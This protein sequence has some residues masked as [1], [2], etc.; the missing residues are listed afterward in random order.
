MSAC[1]A[2]TYLQSKS[3]APRN[4]G[5]A[6]PR[7]PIAP[8]RLFW[9]LV[10][11]SK[12]PDD[13]PEEGASSWLLAAAQ[14]VFSM[15]GGVG[16]S[17]GSGGG[18]GA[19]GGADGGSGG[20][21]LQ[22]IFQRYS[23]AIH[24][25][26]PRLK[27]ALCRHLAS[28]AMAAG[29]FT[30]PLDADEVLAGLL[31]ASV[32]GVGRAAGGGVAAPPPS[33]PQQRAA[34]A[35]GGTAP[36]QPPA[37]SS[38]A[39]FHRVLPEVT[40]LANL[41]LSARGVALT[42]LKR[43]VDHPEELV[44][45]GEGGEGGEYGEGGGGEGGSGGGVGSGGSSGGGGGGGSGG[46]SGGGGGGGG[47][48]TAGGG[49]GS[50]GGYVDMVAVLSLLPP[51]LRAHL[52][53]HMRV[54]AAAAI[55]EG[56]G[57]P[58]GGVEGLGEWRWPVKVYSDVDDT[59]Q[60]RLYDHSFPRHTTYPGYV[61][62]IR[63]L[64]GQPPLLFSPPPP[65]RGAAAAPPPQPP[66]PA[67]PPPAPPPAPP[68]PT[69]PPP[70]APSP[71]PPS[72]PPPPPAP[73]PPGSALFRL[74]LGSAGQGA[75][76]RRL[77]PPKAP[78]AAPP[79]AAVRPPLPQRRAARGGG[80]SGGGEGGEGDAPA[81]SSLPPGDLIFLSARPAF[82]RASTLALAA[83]VGLGGGAVLCGTLAAALT[84]SRMAGRK[85]ANHLIHASCF[86]E[87]RFVF[88]GD[89]GQADVAFALKMLAAHASVKAAVT[90]GFSGAAPGT[91]EF[92]RRRALCAPPPLVLIHDICGADG[93]P[94][95]PSL[96]RARL[97]ARGVH[98]VDSYIDAAVE[99]Y[100]CDLLTDEQLRGV[101]DGATEDL[102]C[103]AWGESGSGG[104]SGSGVGGGLGL[105]PGGDVT[106]R[107]RRHA[108]YRTALM[109]AH[110]ALGSAE[111]KRKPGAALGAAVPVGPAA[112]QHAAQPSPPPAPAAPAAAPQPPAAAEP[113]P[114]PLPPLPLPPASP[115][116]DA[117]AAAQPATPSAAS[118]DAL[119]DEDVLEA[120]LLQEDV[121]EAA[122]LQE[123]VE[124]AVY[125]DD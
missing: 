118:A 39:N 57:G 114:P 60:V 81:S 77:V 55:L 62:L 49:A 92:D 113:A 11:A 102:A 119:F 13:K 30:H 12:M 73:P 115:P 98:V 61:H 45:P 46:G 9:M 19:S 120:A 76:F 32:G 33:P 25:L 74:G 99:A 50:D 78:S 2:F 84:H 8:D 48:P 104:G 106:M 26:P 71:P 121:E 28:R 96:Q 88:F 68:P 43:W 116:P 80:G 64:R 44:D 67:P 52:L 94:L 125:K 51:P 27:A 16:G 109:R 66:P 56:G 89:S 23:P 21:E 54:E 31:Q 97:R 58:R 112:E 53:H 34:G 17:G 85:L 90:G 24:A 7:L 101:I 38:S 59:V 20:S 69:P 108:E 15:V 103:V 93:V 91:P 75:L 111:A 124:E 10:T 117:A 29:A 82:L 63:A 35:A 6:Q 123:D 105:A 65:L 86:P 3:N 22:R 47:V 36:Q 107:D 79:R 122:L 41:F 100:L 72:A 18:G 5:M 1:C 95:T 87:Y 14:S 40:M 42:E 110:L 4:I 83:R 70:R 37:A